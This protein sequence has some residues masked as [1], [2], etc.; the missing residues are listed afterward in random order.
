MCPVL[1]THL[2]FTI[3]S[4]SLSLPDG[5]F[6]TGGTRIGNNTTGVVEITMINETIIEGTFEGTFLSRNRT[7]EE[8]SGRFLIEK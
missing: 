3:S 8:A 1:L 2:T 6:L 4:L 7:L 5:T